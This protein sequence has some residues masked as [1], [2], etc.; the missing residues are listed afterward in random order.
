MQRGR[1]GSYRVRPQAGGKGAGLVCEPGSS[2][3]ELGSS[4]GHGEA[5]ARLA[6]RPAW[7]GCVCSS[8]GRVLPTS[9]G[10]DQVT[11]AR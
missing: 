7:T 11:V 5:A 3:P 6:A 8:E 10:G 2:G 1:R 9:A 4:S